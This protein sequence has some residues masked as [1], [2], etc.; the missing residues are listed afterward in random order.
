[1]H[2]FDTEKLSVLSMQDAS[3]GCLQENLSIST[4][5]ALLYQWLSLPCICVYRRMQLQLWAES[6]NMN[7]QSM[8]WESPL[9]KD[10]GSILQ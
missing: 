9:A 10:G 1:M 4:F 2:K 6:S 8:G 3:P 5:W 7:K